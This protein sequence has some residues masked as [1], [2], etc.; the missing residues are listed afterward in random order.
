MAAYAPLPPEEEE[1]GC[2]KI[3]PANTADY[4]CQSVCRSIHT[5][6]NASY[7]PDTFCH[8]DLHDTIECHCQLAQ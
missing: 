3:L 2:Y 5:T 6:C 8:T 1:A 4:L 7:V